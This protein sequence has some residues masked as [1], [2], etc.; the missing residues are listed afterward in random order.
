[1][2]IQLHKGI[3]SS[4]KI[5]INDCTA[6]H[7][8]DEVSVLRIWLAIET[9]IS[10]NGPCYSAEAFTKLMKDYSVNHIT[11]SPHYP[12]IKWVSGKVHTN[13]EEPIL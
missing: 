10:D 2:N 9:I 6:C 3:P 8:P 4:E 11:S 13:C 7:R 5:D 12:Q 1:M